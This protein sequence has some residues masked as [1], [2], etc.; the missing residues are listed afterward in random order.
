MPGIFEFG[1]LA[2]LPAQLEHLDGLNRAAE[3]WEMTGLPRAST[4]GGAC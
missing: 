2:G 1:E 3:Q 4:S